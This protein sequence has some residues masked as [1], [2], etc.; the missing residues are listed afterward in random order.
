MKPKILAGCGAATVA[1][2]LGMLVGCLVGATGVSAKTS[3]ATSQLG[4]AAPAQQQAHGQSALAVHSGTVLND[5]TAKAGSGTA[6]SRVSFSQGNRAVSSARAVALRA[7]GTLTSTNKSG[8]TRGSRS[9]ADQAA[10]A[11]K[12][13]VTKQQAEQTALT[14]SPGN[15]IDHSRLAETN[16]TVF[17]DVDFTNGGGVTV[18]AQTGAVIATEAAGTDHGGRAK[19]SGSARTRSSTR[20]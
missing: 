18:N 14:T 19:N 8:H 9:R 2:G 5:R 16:G 10:L 7:T 13:T 6:L 15:T 11:A 4:A 12:A 1:I 3:D 20:P 17:W